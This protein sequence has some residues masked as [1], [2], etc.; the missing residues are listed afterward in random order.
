M[1]ILF[2]LN[3][4]PYGNERPYNALRLAINVAKREGML[5]RVFLMGDAVQCA[6]A[7]QKTPDGYYNVE[8]MLRSI[9]SHGEVAT[10][11]TCAQARGL[12]PSMLIEG[13]RPGNMNLLADW[14]VE[15][16]KVLVF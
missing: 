15:A 10:L 14:T 16:D 8:R 11:A 5:V 3:D 13:V 7:K 9:A 1:K 6:V 2:I 4:G 12:E